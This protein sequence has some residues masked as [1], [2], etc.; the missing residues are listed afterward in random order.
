MNEE[1]FTTNRSFDFSSDSQM[2][3]WIRYDES[4]VPIYSIQEFKGAYPT[5]QE[6]DEYPG[7]YNYKYPR[8][9]C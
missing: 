3:A 4:K 1:E 6:Y 5:R 9:R 8:S 7:A 2:L